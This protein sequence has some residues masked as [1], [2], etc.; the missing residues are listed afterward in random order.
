MTYTPFK[1]DSLVE[2]ATVRLILPPTIVLTSQL[3]EELRKAV[4]EIK[5]LFV[6][7]YTWMCKQTGGRWF[8]LI[9]FKKS[10]VFEAVLGIFESFEMR[11]E[12]TWRLKFKLSLS[13]D[14]YNGWHPP[15]I[16]KISYGDESDMDP[17]HPS[18]LQEDDIKTIE[19]W[20]D[21]GVPRNSGRS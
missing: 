19:N 20:R 9:N 16:R 4:V 17:Y 21:Y 10:A 15:M 6:R 13:I 14:T 7:D 8:E 2:K 5:M 1:T 12:N 3:T 18:N 11:E